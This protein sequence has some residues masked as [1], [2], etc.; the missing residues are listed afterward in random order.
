M[1]KAS[2][3]AGAPLSLTTLWLQQ[4]N[5]VPEQLPGFRREG[6]ER[7]RRRESVRQRA[8]QPESRLARVASARCVS[9]LHANRNGC[10]GCVARAAAATSSWFGRIRASGLRNSL[11]AFS[12]APSASRQNSRLFRS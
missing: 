3:C 6:I 11:L 4:T 10:N 5:H 7:R 2:W 12:S 8:H 9:P 1:E